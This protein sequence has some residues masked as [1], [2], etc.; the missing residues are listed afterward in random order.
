MSQAP[1]I[2][3]II[4]AHNEGANIGPCLEAAWGST[5]R[6][7]EVIVVDDCSTDDTAQAAARHPC[8]LIRAGEHL[9]VS[10]ARNLGAQAGQGELLFFTD[11]DCLLEPDCLG[12][13]WEAMDRNPGAVIGGTYA[14]RPADPG[15]FNLFQSILVNHF[16][17][18]H[19]EPDYVA[20]HALLVAKK[21]FLAAGGFEARRHMGLAA[22]V[23]D[24]EFCHRLRRAGHKLLMEPQALVRHRFG[25]NLTRSLA[26]A[27][28]KSFRWSLYSLGNRDLLADSGCASRE[29]KA[30]V[31]AWAGSL[32][33]LAAY[34]AGHGVWFLGLALLLLLVNLGLNARFLAALWRQSGSPAFA[35]LAGLYYLLIYPLPVGAGAGAALAAHWRRG[36]KETVTQGNGQPWPRA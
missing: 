5:H 24:V 4:P 35:C 8:R 19:P 29:L 12:R 11:A 23:E 36:D 22:G 9:G 33:A 31:A 10:R 34:A 32:G 30:N 7:L 15:F 2:S 14:P 18:K 20:A 1:L 21:D 13:A 27:W 25:F 6:P 26:N 3:L 28:W 16:E 17:T